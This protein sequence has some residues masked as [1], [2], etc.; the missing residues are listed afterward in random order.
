MVGILPRQGIW[1]HSPPEA[2]DFF[3]KLLTSEYMKL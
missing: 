1:G 3:F 2:I